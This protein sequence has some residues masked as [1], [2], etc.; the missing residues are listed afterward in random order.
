MFLAR[1]FL[2][3]K[4]TL[5]WKCLDSTNRRNHY[6]MSRFTITDIVK[7]SFMSP[8]WTFPFLSLTIFNANLLTRP[9]RWRHLSRYIRKL[10]NQLYPSV[11]FHIK[12]SH[13]FGKAKQMTDFYME[14]N[15][16]LKWVNETERC[17]LNGAPSW[18]DCEEM[19]VAITKQ[20]QIILINTF[21]NLWISSLVMCNRLLNNGV[22]QNTRW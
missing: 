13:L 8:F 22:M 15:N 3:K 10:L 9:E 18:F 6:S 17:D 20:Q 19:A 2:L 1:P 14:P 7:E 21:Q 4:D 11:V 5:V 16:G 12:T